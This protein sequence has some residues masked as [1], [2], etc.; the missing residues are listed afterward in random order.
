MI[1]F[2]KSILND[3]LVGK[4][5]NIRNYTN[6]DSSFVLKVYHL[7][8]YSEKIC[9]WNEHYY[10]I[11]VKLC[12][13]CCFSCAQ[14]FVTPWTESCQAPLSM[15]FFRQEHWSGLPCPPPGDLPD[16][17]VEPV[18]LVSCMASRFFTTGATWGTQAKLYRH[19]NEHFWIIYKELWVLQSFIFFK[20]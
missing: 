6:W 11:C 17:G 14:L 19:D 2:L 12:V 15:G 4:Q 5:G 8:V 7:H 20:L 10:T 18:G 16:P 3:S 1:N 13:P 9:N